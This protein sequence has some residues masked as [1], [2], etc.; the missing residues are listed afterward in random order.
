MG[1]PRGRPKQREAHVIRP[2]TSPRLDTAERYGLDWGSRRARAVPL[3]VTSSRARV[4][5]WANGE[6]TGVSRRLPVETG[7]RHALA[8]AAKTFKPRSAQPLMKTQ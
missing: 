3:A 6:R 1:R 7:A 2:A 4:F 5:S 8:P